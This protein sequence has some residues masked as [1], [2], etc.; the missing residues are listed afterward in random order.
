MKQTILCISQKDYKNK[1]NINKII[2]IA[3]AVVTIALNV[4]FCI[5]RNDENHQTMLIL[6]IVVDIVGCWA[7]VVVV[8]FFIAPYSQKLKLYNSKK[9]L[10]SVVKKFVTITAH[11]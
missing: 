9:T 1:L 4:L 6:N 11:I 8:S 10:F 5:L 7:L 3:I 2:C